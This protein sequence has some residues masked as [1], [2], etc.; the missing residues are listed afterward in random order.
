MAT[1]AEL[2]AQVDHLTAILLERD[3]KEATEKAAALVAQQ[4]AEQATDLATRAAARREEVAKI[5]HGS[6]LSHLLG[7]VEDKNS[8]LDLAAIEQKIPNDGSWPPGVDK[9][10]FNIGPGAIKQDIDLSATTLGKLRGS[11]HH[12]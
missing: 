4:S 5:C 12:G 9:S 11:K 1:N 3:Q 2:Q 8:P 10:T 6:W 7:Q